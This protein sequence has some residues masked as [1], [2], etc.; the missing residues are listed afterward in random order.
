MWQWFLAGSLVLINFATILIV[1]ALLRLHLRRIHDRR[2]APTPAD[3][4]ADPAAAATDALARLTGLADEIDARLAAQTD[5]LERLLARADD[6]IA[7][8]GNGAPASGDVGRYA[9][10]ADPRRREIRRLAG[11][12]VDSV[13]IARRLEMDVGEVELVLN[14]GRSGPAEL[15]S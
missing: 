1:I 3:R 2:S 9:P 7:R 12:Q 10:V 8:L 5:R 13:E 15:D 4:I 14:L 11:Q 6:K